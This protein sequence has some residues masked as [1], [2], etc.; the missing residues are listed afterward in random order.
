MIVYWD[1]KYIKYYTSVHVITTFLLILG[2]RCCDEEDLKFPEGFLIGA[3]SSAY[4]IEGAWNIS[5]KAESIWDHF[6]HDPAS[7]VYNKSTGDVASNS[8]YLYKEDIKLLSQIGFDFYR[9]SISWSRILPNGFANNISQDGLKYYHNLLDELNSKDVKPFVTLYHWDHPQVLEKLGGWTNE[10]MVQWFTD[11]AKV[12]FRELGP[13]VK[14]FITINEPYSLCSSGYGD[15][16][17]APGMNL[18]GVANYICGHNMLKAHANV[19]HMYHE[20]FKEDQ[21][22]LI[23][24]AN[25]C[26][27]FFAK[28]QT[29]TLQDEAFQF[30]CGWF[31]HPIFSKQGDYPAVMKALINHNSIREGWQNSRLPIFSKK[32]INYIKG[33]ADF[34]ALNHYTSRIVERGN[35]G[36][37]EN[38]WYDLKATFTLDPKWPKGKSSWLAV[39]PE[40]LRYILKKLKSEYGNTSIYIIENG[41]SDEGQLEDTKRVEY[42]FFYLREML[43][44]IHQDGCNVKAYTAWSLLDNFE[45]TS[46]YSERFGIIHVDFN[47]ST[48]KRT[49]KYS[50]N[51]FK[52]L[53][54]FRQLSLKYT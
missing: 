47:D 24:I 37:V 17:F 34:Y 36:R 7:G 1:L 25:E 13:K 52:D 44:A 45:W 48:R 27:S 50:A 14:V 28:N 51:W 15:S 10:L 9:F 19:Y 5:D 33:T 43:K 16:Y 20:E 22:G 26:N 4:Q 46:G 18:P 38:K 49:A 12:V 11:Y 8:Y 30:T 23:G 35:N 6:T 32:W 54:K 2:T 31:S 21:R 3:G 42:Y 41:F 53:L 40:G 39:A 29:D